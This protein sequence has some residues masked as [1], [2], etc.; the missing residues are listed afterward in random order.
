MSET[1]RPAILII[2]DSE[3]DVMLILRQL[4]AEGYEPSIG[5]VHTLEE[6]RDTLASRRWDVIL[7]DYSMPLFNG[8]DA[9]K[10][11]RESGVDI[12][13]ILVSGRIGE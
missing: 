8:L 1:K 2:E 6:I 5:H 9:L 10:A 7:S 13:F 11:V 12:P 3:D 4:R